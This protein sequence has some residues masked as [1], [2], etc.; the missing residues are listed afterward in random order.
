MT[1]ARALAVAIPAITA[2]LAGGAVAA[3]EVLRIGLVTTLSGPGAVVGVDIRD[4]F[5]LA[6]DQGG[7]R[8]G[9]LDTVVVEAD[10]QQKPEVAVGLANRMVERDRV[11]MVT[12]VI[13]S[14]LALAMMPT[15][16]GAGVFL[17]SPNAGPSQLAGAQCNP[18][19]FNVSWAVDSVGEAAGRAARQQGYA[20]VHL[21]APNYP[22]GKDVVA[23]FKRAFGPDIAGET[24]TQFGQLEYAAEI[25]AIKATRPDGVFIFFPGGM[26]IAFL[27]QWEQA[28]L[29]GVVPLIGP[30]FTFDQDVLG[31]AG[32]AAR[33][34]KN[35][36]QWSPDLDNPANRDFVAAFRARFHRQ[37]SFYAAQAYDTAR[38]MDGAV[39][40]TGGDLKDKDRLRQALA[41]APFASVRGDFRFNTNHYPIQT[42]YLRQVVDAADGGLTNRVIGTVVTDHADVYARDCPMK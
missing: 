34:V 31:A 35:V 36:L 4:G 3:G 21:I 39:R 22:A 5:Q 12:G 10:D 28:G 42:Y 14:N 41:A 15:L 6:L 27:K 13:W 2:S 26:G 1:G 18:Y 23:G 9:G 40:R 32:A 16:A 19:F 17:I 11:Q 8:L 25:A 30:G 37:P 7:G 29:A 24:F 33:G 20:R 38:L